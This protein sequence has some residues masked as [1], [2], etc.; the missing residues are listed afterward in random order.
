V[1]IPDPIIKVAVA[2]LA[3]LSVGGLAY[4]FLYPYLSK[5]A[6][7]EK[8]VEKIAATR[9]P[10]RNEVR[11][12]VDPTAK[13]KQI[14]EQLKQ[15]SERE[16]RVAKSPSLQ[17]RIAQAGLTWSLRTFYIISAI[18][19]L[20]AALVALL[21]SGN[22]LIALAIGFAFAFGFPRWLLTFM[23]KRRLLR[24]INEFPNAV[25]VIVRGVKAGLPLGDCIR[26]CAQEAQEPVRSEFKAIV[27]TQAI[28]MNLAD[29]V[30]RLYERVPLPEA[31]FFA[32]V[33]A[34]QQRS[35]GNLSEVLGNLSKVLRDRKKMKQ[36]IIALSQ[37]AKASAAIIAA[38]P[39][40]V[41]GIV[42]FTSPDYISLLWTTPMGQFM[43]VCC[44]AWMT[45][46]IMVMRKMIN[47]D[48]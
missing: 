48:F 25:D 29:A 32:I 31:N 23:R 45:L 4:V 14:E 16:A 34:V 37:E 12:A 38:L 7:A 43:L 44:A 17:V 2:G 8:R 41:M 21:I 11:A 33:I 18:S 1:V 20:G 9:P 15:I 40:T 35:G 42:S 28:G 46:G 13:R 3:A 22:L 24:F 30:E 6:A 26:I 5:Q 39:L 27:E 10:H 19:G 36:K 47:F